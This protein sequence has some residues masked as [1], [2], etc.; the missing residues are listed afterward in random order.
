MRCCSS[1]VTLGQPSYHREMGI[2]R[3]RRSLGA[4][5]AFDVLPKLT[6]PKLKITA[7]SHS[8][9]SAD[10][11][12]AADQ[13]ISWCPSILPEVES[14]LAGASSFLSNTL[15]PFDNSPH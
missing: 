7:S 5:D 4:L 6:R 2:D 12:A 15:F 11:A 9:S 14:P 8:S 1:S 3:V 13:G 10:A